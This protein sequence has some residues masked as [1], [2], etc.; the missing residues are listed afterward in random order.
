MTIVAVYDITF[1]DAAIFA[2]ETGRLSLEFAF[3]AA[4]ANMVV[5]L[6]T[7]KHQPN[8]Q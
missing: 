6:Q 1:S 3:A 2:V 5:I 7:S 8:F 4:N